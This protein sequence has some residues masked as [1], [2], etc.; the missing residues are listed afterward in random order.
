L[1]R[2]EQRRRLRVCLHG[3][4]GLGAARCAP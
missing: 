2:K 1:H 4:I 3:L